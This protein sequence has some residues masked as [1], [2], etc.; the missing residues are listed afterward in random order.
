VFSYTGQQD[1]QQRKDWDGYESSIRKEK[2]LDLNLPC[3]RNKEYHK[4]TYTAKENIL[5]WF[6]K[7]KG[8]GNSENNL[9]RSFQISS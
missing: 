3:E 5:P 8:Q 6:V 4:H 7:L 1:Q 9:S 2:G